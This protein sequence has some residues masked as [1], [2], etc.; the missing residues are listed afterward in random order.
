[1]LSKTCH[2]TMWRSDSTEYSKTLYIKKLLKLSVSLYKLCEEFFLVYNTS[3]N[4]FIIIHFTGVVLS[5][6]TLKDT[7]EHVC[8]NDCGRKYKYKPSLFQHLKFE[9]GVPR[10]FH[11]EI[12]YRAFAQ[13]ISFRKHMMNKHKVIL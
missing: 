12:C 9:C 13:K 8:P 5:S 1:M 6:L 4:Y 10:K 11:C 3:E 7:A 2:F